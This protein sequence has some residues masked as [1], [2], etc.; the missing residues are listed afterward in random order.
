MAS[1][2]IQIVPSVLPC[3][4]GALG[5]DLERLEDAGVDK[6]QFDVMDGHFVPNLTFGADVIKSSRKYSS[7]P[8]EAH[9]MIE[10]PENTLERYV[11]A[12]C[13][14]VIVHAEATTHLHRTLNQI[15][16]LGAKSAVALN[17]ATPLCDIEYVLTS[18]DMVL[19]MTVN[20]G[21]GGQAYIAEME[22]KIARLK[23]MLESLK[24]DI[25]IEVDGGI[26]PKTVEGAARAGA[27]HLVSGSSIFSS[28]LGLKA[29][30]A[31]LRELAET[32]SK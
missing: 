3:D 5:S 12:G 4:F 18:C 21:F 30:V 26:S 16:G 29:A 31:E 19:I 1:E 7:L 10:A 28:P 9:L 27:T 15:R 20:P 6:I 23:E 22:P 8:F 2:R 13:D 14:L 25:P 24:L 17:P 32:A 11:D